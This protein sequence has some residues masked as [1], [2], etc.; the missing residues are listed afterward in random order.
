MAPDIVGMRLARDIAGL[1]EV[2][3]SGPSP[4]YVWAVDLLRDIGGRDAAD[5]LFDCVDRPDEYPRW[6][7][8]HAL[9]ALA[10]LRD[11]RALPVILGQVRRGAPGDGARAIRMYEDLGAIGGPEAVRELVHRLGDPKPPRVVV[12]VVARLRPPEA[13]PALMAALWALLPGAEQHT[14]EALGAM[15]DP[16]TGPAL[17]YLVHS[18]GTSPRLRR[19]AVLA[20]A[21]IPEDSWPPPAG[22]SAEVMLRRA[23]RD[24]DASTARPAAALLARTRNGRDELRADLMNTTPRHAAARRAPDCSAV[25]VC[26]LIQERPDLFGPAQD[27]RDLPTL[28]ELL[29]EESVPAVRRAAASALGALGGE[30]AADALLAALG[31]ARIGDAVARAL[32]TLPTPPPVRELLAALADGSP[33][34]RDRRRS[35]AVALGL[36]EC[37]DAAPLLLAALDAEDPRDIRSAAADALGALR[38]GPAADRLASLAGDGEEPGTLRARAVHA[39][40]LIGARE[41]LPVLLAA[42]RD[43]LE[44][45]RVQAAQALGRFPV[46]EAADMLG[47]LAAGDAS[48]DVARGAVR[49]LGRIGAPGTHVLASLAEPSRFR[50]NVGHELVAALAGCPGAVAVAAL[51]GLAVSPETA[52]VRP[53]ATEA[54]AARRSPDCV[55]PLASVLATARPG[56]DGIALRG[57]AALGTAEADAH[58][59]TY[60]RTKGLASEAAREALRTIADRRR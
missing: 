29:G 25:T 20:L 24:P 4:Y 23:L 50:R 9:S 57:L 21:E 17:L 43:P 39:L 12:E 40:G 37:A 1:V 55:A 46:A 51:A 44:P 8:L 35:A 22:L 2:M 54:L 53:P 56:H 30:E 3:R 19:A 48:R 34:G 10:E 49:A 11:R 5:A 27:Y 26:A 52:D 45:V 28:I 42:A 41:S 60:C 33:G 18:R 31:D 15:R 6:L 47:E 59:L 7:H 32:S 58:V 36:L 14:V 38:H 16:R 13:V